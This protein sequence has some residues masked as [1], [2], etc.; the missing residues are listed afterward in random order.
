MELIHIQQTI[1]GQGAVNSV[2]ARE[3]HTKLEVKTHLSTW[4]KRSIE[5]YD[6]E[7][8]IDFSVLKSGNPNGGLPIIDYIV[9]LDMA[10]ELCML[11][12]GEKG[13]QFRKYFIECEKRATKQLSAIEQIALLARGTTELAETVQQ[14]AADIEVLKND[15]CL[16]S[17]QKRNLQKKVAVKI[18]AFNPRPE[19]KSKLFAATWGAIK[20]HFAVSSYMEIPRVRFDEAVSFLDEIQLDDLLFWNR[21]N[22]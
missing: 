18:A 6:F 10:K 13:K 5:K 14:H 1:I 22:K 3:L 4:I 7:E 21:G 2:N 15:I 11:D 12:D 17:A 16:S 8:N 19:N 9:S 20:D